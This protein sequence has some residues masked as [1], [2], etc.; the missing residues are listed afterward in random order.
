[1]NL[2]AATLHIADLHEFAACI[3]RKKKPDF[4]LEHDLVVQE[5]LLRASRMA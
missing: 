2:P 5:A 1:M 3:A 4:S